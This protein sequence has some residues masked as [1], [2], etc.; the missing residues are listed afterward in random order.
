MNIHSINSAFFQIWFDTNSSFRFQYGS[1]RTL[2][3]I[4]CLSSLV[5]INKGTRVDAHKGQILICDETTYF[6]AKNEPT[7]FRG[8]TLSITEPTSLPIIILNNGIEKTILVL[9]RKIFSSNEKNMNKT[10]ANELKQVMSVISEY[11]LHIQAKH[12]QRKSIRYIDSRLIFI[13]RYIRTHFSQPLTLQ[14]LADLISCNPVYLCNRFTKV[15]KISPIKQIQKFRMEEAQKLLL[16]TDMS[17]LEI[18]RT[19]SYVSCSHFSKYFK[20]YFGITPLDYRKKKVKN[21]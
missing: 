4:E 8:I 10:Y 6:S 17:V 7:S 18:S 1:N 3:V 20:R 14:Q 5:C 16:Q 13:H 2:L 19:L 11:Y 15:F 12:S 9:L 21:M